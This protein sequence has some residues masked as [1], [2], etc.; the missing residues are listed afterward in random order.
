M[1]ESLTNEGATAVITHRVREEHQAEYERWL[2]EIAPLCRAYPGHLDWHIVRPIRG[3]TG[4]YT[5]VIQMLGYG[6]RRIE[7]VQVQAGQASEVAVAL[8]SRAI[9]LDP[10]QV[11]V[12]KK[13]EKATEAPAT[14]AVVSEAKVQERVTAGPIEH[15]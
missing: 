4:T 10:I 8:D 7:G 12:G 11:T 5:V 3:L 1:A 15:S 6:E 14:V 2:E 9:M 13:A